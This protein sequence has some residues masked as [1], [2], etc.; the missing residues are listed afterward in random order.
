M[1]ALLWI[2]GVLLALI[3]VII[4][5]FCWMFGSSGASQDWHHGQD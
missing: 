1:N 3:V 5:G 4:A 2:G